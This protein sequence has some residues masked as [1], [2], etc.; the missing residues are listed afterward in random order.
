MAS[1]PFSV[2]SSWR[3]FRNSSPSLLREPLVLPAGL[4]DTPLGHLFGPPGFFSSSDIAVDFIVGGLD[5]L[6]PWPGQ[7][8][9]EDVVSSLKQGRAG[10]L[11]PLQTKLFQKKVDYLKAGSNFPAHVE[12]QAY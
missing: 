2:K 1:A 11:S 4:P 7:K 6:I 5:K 9:A 3:A 12:E 8:E 10:L